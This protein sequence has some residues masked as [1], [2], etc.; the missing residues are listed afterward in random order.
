[1]PPLDQALTKLICDLEARGLLDA[2]LIVMM[3]EFGRA[4]AINREAGREPR[5]NVMSLVLA[6]GGLRHGQMIGATTGRGTASSIA[7]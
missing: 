4:A 2:T 7:R 3:G 5:T 6:G 1:M